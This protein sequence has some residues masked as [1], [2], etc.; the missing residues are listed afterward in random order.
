[1]P[2][3]NPIHNNPV[4]APSNPFTPIA[5]PIP[6]TPPPASSPRAVANARLHA[7]GIVQ[8][9]PHFYELYTGPKL[10]ELNA[11]NASGELSPQGTFKFTGTN[12]GAINKGPAV[13][14]WGVDRN[15]NLPVG[16]FANRPNIRF[17]A[18][19]V[20]SL[21]SS[22]TPSAQVVDLASGATTALP[23]SSVKIHGHMVSV[24]LSA[25]LLPSTG[26]P[27]SQYRF[28]FWPEPGGPSAS[29]ASFAPEFT[30]AQVGR[31]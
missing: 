21:S 9:D 3:S 20:V 16:P 29:V 8:K 12:K 24:K 18:V 17:D 10:A 4:S 19:V 26:L 2:I 31:K 15:G 5:G 11:V 1:M 14:V 6:K 27:P 25:S 7:T 30:T 28:N 22:R 13:Y 23:S